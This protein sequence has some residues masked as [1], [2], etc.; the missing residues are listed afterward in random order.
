[1]RSVPKQHIILVV[2]EN[3]PLRDAITY[4]LREEGHFVLALADGNLALDVARDNPLSL[5]IFD[6]AHLQPE[7]LDVCRAIRTSPK[8]DSVP[9]LMVVAHESEIAQIVRQNELR[10]NDFILKPLHWEELRVCVRALLRGN[11]PRSGK[12]IHQPKMETTSEEGQL[13]VADELCIDVA[14]R[15][16]FLRDQLIELHQMRLFDL[17]V[18]L[19]RHRGIVLTRDQLLIDVWGYDH[20]IDTRTVDVHVRWLRQKLEDAPDHPQLIETVRGVG[21]RFKD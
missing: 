8:T 16:V 6:P 2:E 15:T 19:V 17:L 1:M 18:Y 5:V 12:A 3:R 14:R 11:R 7:G 21:Y 10:V 20:G 9:I 13:L 4:T